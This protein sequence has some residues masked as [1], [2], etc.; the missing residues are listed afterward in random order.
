MSKTLFAAALL[1]TA[2]FAHADLLDFSGDICSANP[3]GSGAFTACSNFAPVNQAYGDSAGV[4][5]S[6][7]YDTG[8]PTASMQFW[9]DAYSGMERVSFGGIDPSITLTALGGSAISLTGF[10]LGSWPNS[11]RNSQVTVVDLATNATILSTG[12]IAVLGSTPSSFSF[13][14]T[15]STVG[16]RIQF[17]P[18]GYNVGIDNLAFTV[19]AVPEPKSW[20]LMVGGAL[21]LGLRRRSGE[22]C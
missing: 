10:D 2:Q 20:L 11:T 7:Q 21:L 6:Y 5:V 18:E 12:T 3:D 14:N 1:A 13:S 4:N 19:S 9:F 15:V 17:G 8:N 16:F 22:R